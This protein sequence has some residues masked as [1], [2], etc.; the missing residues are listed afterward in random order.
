MNPELWLIIMPTLG[1]SLFALGG[2]QISD[3]I[4]GQKWLRRFLL[5]FLWAACVKLAHF[6]L[7]QAAGVGILACGLFHLGYGEK[8]SWKMR[9]L[10]FAGY[11]L[12]SAPIGLSP[13]N[14]ISVIGCI[15]MF[16]L[17]NFKPTS[18]VFV[19]KI[20][21]GFMGF[22]IGIQL[23]FLISGNGLIWKF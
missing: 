9:L 17:S 15:G 3:K 1:L 6:S 18:W 11:G 10:V 19:W 13:W 22:N 2:T 4:E 16:F 12:I 8:T 7:W 21:E 5:P 14:A 20:V 23:G